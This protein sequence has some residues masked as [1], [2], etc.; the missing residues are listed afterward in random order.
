MAKNE[1]TSK[2]WCDLIFQGKNQEYG[3]YQMRIN[4]YKR[5]NWALLLVFATLL[6]AILVYKVID[7]VTPKPKEEIARVTELSQLSAPVVIEKEKEKIK[8]NPAGMKKRGPIP[9]ERTPTQ[10][11]APRITA[12]PSDV[13]GTLKKVDGKSA[14]VKVVADNLAKD[15]AQT[16]VASAAAS[17]MVAG[18]FGKGSALVTSGKGGTGTKSDGSAQGNSDTGKK[19]GM[20]GNGTFDLDGRSLGP[21]GLPQPSYN[22]REEGK[23]VVTIVVNPSGRVISTSINKMTNTVNSALRKAAEDAAKKARF[24]SVGASNNQTGTITYYFKFK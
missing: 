5:H 21:G 15:D 19:S 23:V 11:S 7:S 12:E 8:S 10:R 18:A 1:I 20:G 17:K 3:A 13:G 16:K 6:F 2:E 9:F 4:S 14:K 24:N 22:V